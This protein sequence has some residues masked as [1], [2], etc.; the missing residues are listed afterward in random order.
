MMVVTDR[1]DDSGTTMEVI[2]VITVCHFFFECGLSLT[3]L[4]MLVVLVALLAQ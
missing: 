2:I 4:M 3:A 1:A